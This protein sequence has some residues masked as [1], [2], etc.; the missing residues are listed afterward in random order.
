MLLHFIVTPPKTPGHVGF[1]DDVTDTWGSVTPPAGVQSQAP[2]PPHKPVSHSLPWH[3]GLA[4]H[5]DPFNALSDNVGV[6]H[7]HQRD[8]DSSH[9]AHGTCP[10]SC[11]QNMDS[12]AL[13]APGGHWALLRACMLWGPPLRKARLR[14]RPGQHSGAR[15]KCTPTCTV[16]HTGRLDGAVRCLHGRDPPH[17]KVIRPHTDARHWAVLND[18]GA[19]GAASEATQALSALTTHPL[20]TPAPR[21]REPCL[22][23]GR[24]HVTPVG[25]GATTGQN[26]IPHVP[27]PGDL[28]PH[29]GALFCKEIL[30]KEVGAHLIERCLW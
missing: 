7:G 25:K 2:A 9:P 15:R 12:S 4:S 13:P 24:P 18:L 21:D 19:T 8:L 29:T 6:V 16:D 5:L 28:S 3:L 1:T 17:P 14:G 11:G 30:N 26:L 22:C 27:R 23:M 10:H 20:G